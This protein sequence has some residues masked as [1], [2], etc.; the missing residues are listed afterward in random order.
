MKPRICPACGARMC[1]MGEPLHDPEEPII[2]RCGPRLGA[3]AWGHRWRCGC[4]VRVEVETPSPGQTEFLKR[5][6]RENRPSIWERIRR[7]FCG[8]M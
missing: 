3:V 8:S 4:G 6:E 1:L 7:L 5:W 2:L